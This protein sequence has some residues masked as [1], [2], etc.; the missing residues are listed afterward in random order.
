MPGRPGPQIGLEVRGPIHY[1]DRM[2][3]ILGGMGREGGWW[4]WLAVG[5]IG[6]GP[7]ETAGGSTG[8]DTSLDA[9]MG[10]AVDAVG[11]DATGPGLGSDGALG[12]GGVEDGTTSVPPDSVASVDSVGVGE[13]EDSGTGDAVNETAS[14]P[15]ADA[16][17]VG[18]LTD[19]Q[20]GS[21]EVCCTNPGAYLSACV[22][23][24]NCSAGLHDACLVDEQC[25][26]R[27]PGQWTVCCHDR[28]NRNYCAPTRDTCQ[29][30]LA[31]EGP[32]DCVGNGTEVCCSPH[33]YYRAWFCTNE[34]FAASPERDC[35]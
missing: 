10:D 15:S 26:A 31:C 14:A 11:G 6:C 34:F 30:L 33:A 18:C 29:P 7:S 4:M 19:S 13:V 17:E 9:A 23:A 16:P 35:P 2:D 28:G 21:G 25:A 3:T 1:G 8:G 27:R 22:A 12:D 32:G 24:E 20:C 5:I